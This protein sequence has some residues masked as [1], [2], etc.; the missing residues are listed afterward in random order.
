VSPGDIGQPGADHG[1]TNRQASTPRKAIVHDLLITTVQ[2]EGLG[3]SYTGT[4]AM[5]IM[6]LPL[7]PG[8][9]GR[10]LLHHLLEH[11]DI[12]GED[13]A[14]RKII[15]L[16]VDDWTLERLLTFDADAAELEDGGDDEPDADDEED[17]APVLV[18]LVRPKL[19]AR[20][21]AVASGSD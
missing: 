14:G 12:V 7:P 15:Q 17:R 13:T 19:V 21:P 4:T 10:A 3:W 18:E 6:P 2:V 8:A 16:A 5:A 20:R 11:G 1:R 9:E